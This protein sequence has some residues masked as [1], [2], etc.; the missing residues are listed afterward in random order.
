MSWF[1]RSRRACA[2]VAF[3]SLRYERKRKNEENK[4]RIDATHL[5]VYNGIALW[6]PSHA[7]V[8]QRSDGTPGNVKVK[9][10][11]GLQF[12][13]QTRRP[14]FRKFKHACARTP[15]YKSRGHPSSRSTAIPSF[16][17]SNE[18]FP[19]SRCSPPFVGSYV[20]TVEPFEFRRKGDR[21]R[22]FGNVSGGCF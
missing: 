22:A 20:H 9:S 3:S 8:S 12:Q 15:P 5:R 10:V 14:I 21:Q 4:R 19:N 2:I 13:I 1:L 16:S 18:I 7:H 17:M 11:S 6:R